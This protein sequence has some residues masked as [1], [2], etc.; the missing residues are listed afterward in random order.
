V[1]VVN[2]P[3]GSCRNCLL[4]H[5]ASWAALALVANM[6][7]SGDGDS[8]AVDGADEM[9]PPPASMQGNDTERGRYMGT[10]GLSLPGDL[11][12]SHTAVVPRLGATTS[13]DLQRGVETAGFVMASA[14]DG[15]VYI[16][17]GSSPTITKYATD[18]AGRLTEVG[19]VSFAAYGVSNVSR[20]PFIGS[21]MVAP[22]KA[23]YFDVST[24]Q[25]IIWNPLSMEITGNVVDLAE[26]LTGSIE[27]QWAVRAFLNYGEGFA[28]QRGNRLFVP[29]RW[30]NADDVSG[31]VRPRAGLLVLDTETDSVVHLLQDDRIADSIYT[32]MLD[33]GDLYLF[34][35]GIGVSQ[36]HLYE[37]AAPGG[38]LRVRNGEDIFDPDYYVN[39]NQAVGGRPATTPVSA[40]GTSV[41]VRVYYDE[42][43]GPQKDPFELL[44]LRAWRY[45]KVDLVGDEPAQEIA[46]LPWTSTDGFFYSLPEENR[47]F[48]GVMNADFSATRLYEAT[49]SG[50]V[51]A[52]EV[53]GTL[54]VLTQLDRKM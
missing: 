47:T 43:G 7:C 29:V 32:V 49:P 20:G 23:Y 10:I 6:G 19:E 30:Q 24:L 34:S 51:E 48:L 17:G 13:A 16:P 33:S 1:S 8:T 12:T 27:P 4:R 5:S 2:S 37:N 28:R 44:A 41:Y 42:Q 14:Y 54:N 40:G 46:E 11:Q 9:A 3:I 21:D 38:A 39:L 22:D 25:L 31:F 45:W 26:V 35:G 53:T 52:F 50:F 36:H 18:E 15:F